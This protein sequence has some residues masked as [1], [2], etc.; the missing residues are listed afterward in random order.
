[1]LANDPHLGA[2]MPSVW[3]QAGLHCRTPGPACPFDVTGFTFSGLPGVVIG[4]NARIAWGF[5]NLGPDVTDLFLEKVTGGTYESA[6]RQ[7]PLVTRTEQIK[8]AGAD[9]V[10]LTVN[11][12]DDGPLITDVIA[13]AGDTLKD[14]GA[15]AV[16]LRWTALDPGRTADALFALDTAH[17]WASFRAAL[18]T[19][20]VPGQNLVYADTDGNI[21]YQATGTVP[22][23]ARG[24][25]RWPVPGWTGEYAWTS[26][27]PYDELPSVFNPAEG[28]IVTANDAVVDPQRYPLL[29]TEDWSYGYRSQRILD[30]LREAVGAG[31]VDADAMAR[32]QGDTHNP[33]A[34]ALVPALLK[35]GVTG[36]ATKALDLLRGWD[37]SQDKDSAA[38]AYFNAVWRHVLTDTFNDD[39][40]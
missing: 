40:P 35:A 5:T 37:F 20:Q 19:F 26:T 4:H 9:P 1:M 18:R 12:T 27:I 13:G 15:N 33:V 32:I 30:Q 24:D 39:L 25:G 28:Y 34:E 6:G 29:L 16:A 21:G 14:S 38:A 8:V 3:Y 31:K 10:T 11:T 23:R 17:D 22:V 7:K 2:A 36:D